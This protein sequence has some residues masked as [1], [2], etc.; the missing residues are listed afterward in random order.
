MPEPKEVTQHR[1]AVKQ[2]LEDGDESSERERDQSLASAVEVLDDIR[3]LIAMGIELR[4]QLTVLV[5]KEGPNFLDRLAKHLGKSSDEIID[6][7][8]AARQEAKVDLD[9]YKLQH[10]PAV[11]KEM[12]ER[13]GVQPQP[14]ED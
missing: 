6:A 5:R 3:T 10:S 1:E 9:R 4:D 11:L 13:F 8:L 7:V 12:K 2:F 14:G